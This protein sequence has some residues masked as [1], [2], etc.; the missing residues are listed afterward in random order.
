MRAATE[1]FMLR[2]FW[3]DENGGTA[4][5]YALIAGSIAMAIIAGLL[6]MGPQLSNIF[7][8]VGNSM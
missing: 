3:N 5:E 1:P 8:N 7:S 2:K 6:L 4:I